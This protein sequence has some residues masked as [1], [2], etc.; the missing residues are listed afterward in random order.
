MLNCQIRDVG[1]SFFKGGFNT[2]V[3]HMLDARFLFV[4]YFVSFNDNAFL[5]KVLRLIILR[6]G[7]IAYFS[8]SD[9]MTGVFK[10]L[11]GVPK[12]DRLKDRGQTK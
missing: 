2:S 3:L 1:L 4:L 8:D 9:I 7:E 5:G 11:V 12:S 10:L 6:G